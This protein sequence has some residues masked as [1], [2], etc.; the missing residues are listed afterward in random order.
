MKK[1]PFK[2]RY[3]TLRSFI[4]GDGKCKYIGDR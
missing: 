2:E 1:R 4:K 3:P